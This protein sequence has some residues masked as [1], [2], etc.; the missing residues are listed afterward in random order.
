MQ[1]LWQDA[2]YAWRTLRKQPGFALVAILTL[3]LGIGANSAIFSVV[4]AVLLRPLPLQEP[5]RLVNIWETF[6]FAGADGG[7]G[8]GTASVPNLRDWR[9]QNDVF[10][11]IAAYQNA[12][13]NL[14]GG[15]S[16]ER[17]PGV[18]ASPGF[19]EVAGGTPLLGRAFQ[20]GED[21]P[22]Q[23]RV[24]VLSHQLW[25]RQFA[26][27][28]QIVGRQLTLNGESFTVIGV[29]PASFRYPGRLTALW[30]PLVI[31][32]SQIN[33][34][35]NHYLL[36]IGRLKPGVSLQ[37]AQERMSVIAR[38][39]E[40][41]YPQNQAGRGI[42]LIPA[43]E[44]VV[45]F[46]RPAL[47][48]LLGAAGFVLLIAC[49][50][51]ANLLLVRA[52][53]RRREIAIRAALGAQRMRLAR[54]FLT[55]S[56]LLSVSSGVLGLLIAKWGVGALV[57]MATTILPRA[58]E[59]RLDGRVVAFTFL[60]SLLTG[61][62]FGLAPALHSAKPDVQAALKE[63][64]GAGSGAQ[65]NWLRGSLVV[66]ETASAVILLIGAGLLIKSFARLQQLDLGFQPAN[67]LTFR[68]SLPDAKYPTP[69]A[70][71]AFHQQTLD[72]VAALPGVQAAGV[73][74]LL[75]IQQTGTNSGIQFEGR[76]PFPPNQG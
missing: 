63:G 35:G 29:M 43:Q 17:L 34:R 70:A 59:V 44:Q 32:D 62:V 26:A 50:N 3:A 19:F 47:R 40:Q 25:Q 56:V 74:N 46:I 33:N 4:N 49:A 75:P 58:H 76:A 6:K 57:A 5:E 38:R 24:V 72:R 21:Q 18:T 13:F 52:T 53:G 14:Q 9:E 73:I 67:A 22:G 45:Q 55:E 36:S 65:G 39:L 23:H 12:S 60:L 16:P 68:L 42:L 71:A 30:T 64:G 20:S 66:L 51:V 28:P 2:R 31:P 1:T 27:D 7:T 69:Q 10:T 41:D 11:D 54:Q 15:E 61:L 37:Q 48:M 8:T